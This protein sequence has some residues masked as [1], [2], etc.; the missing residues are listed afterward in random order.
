MILRFH[1]T[2][3]AFPEQYD[4][5]LGEEKVA[6]ARLRHG[7]FNVCCPDVDGVHVY[8]GLPAGDGCFFD[9]ADRDYFLRFAAQAILRWIAD[10]RP[11]KPAERPP[12]PDIE[13]ELTGHHPERDI[14]YLS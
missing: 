7:H 11:S 3:D 8:E 9:D 13:Y 1:K 5:F 6:Y 2:N 14:G 12:A 4:V 10:N